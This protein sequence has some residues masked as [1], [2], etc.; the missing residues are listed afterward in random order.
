[1][2]LHSLGKL[3]PFT[4]I[5]Q[6]FRIHFTAQLVHLTLATSSIRLLGAHLCI[7]RVAF[8]ARQKCGDGPQYTFASEQSWFLFARR[9]RA[10]RLVLSC[11]WWVCAVSWLTGR[12][13]SC[14]TVAVAIAI[15]SGATNATTSCYL[16]TWSCLCYHCRSEKQQ[17]NNEYNKIYFKEYIYAYVYVV[18]ENISK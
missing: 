3:C 5:L 12:C 4:Q 9:G 2:H 17:N 10:G 7:A 18:S 13:A 6:Q 14:S 1:M 8:V 11:W 15:A 16:H